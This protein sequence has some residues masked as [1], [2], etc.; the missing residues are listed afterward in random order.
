[1]SNKAESQT[2]YSDG[3]KVTIVANVSLHGMEIGEVATVREVVVRKYSL[4]YLRVIG[5]DGKLWAVE[6]GEVEPR[7]VPD[8]R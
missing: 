7:R 4:D 6:M 1:M 2:V 8:V 3:D 5:E